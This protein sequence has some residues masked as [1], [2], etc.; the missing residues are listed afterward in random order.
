MLYLFQLAVKT[1]FL[2]LDSIWLD[3]CEKL[4]LKLLF[5][6][7]LLSFFHLLNGHYFQICKRVAWTIC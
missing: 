6:E 5:T 4:K 3:L 7:I 1:T 2:I